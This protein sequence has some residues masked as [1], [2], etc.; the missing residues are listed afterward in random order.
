[1]DV[2]R[3]HPLNSNRRRRLGASRQN[4]CP[5]RLQQTKRVEAAATNLAFPHTHHRAATAE[6]FKSQQ[7]Q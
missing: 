4:L 6:N 7:K 3:R 1:V 5:T 2:A